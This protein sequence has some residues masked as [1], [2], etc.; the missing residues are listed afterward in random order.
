MN[1]WR[2]ILPWVLERWHLMWAPNGKKKPATCISGEQVSRKRSSKDKGL[3]VELAWCAWGTYEKPVWL[4][5][6]DWQK[7][8]DK[9]Q[10]EDK[11]KLCTVIMP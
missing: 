4:K 11:A 10:E 1:D 5:L 7:M 9:V 6:N 2:I 8:Q 3:E